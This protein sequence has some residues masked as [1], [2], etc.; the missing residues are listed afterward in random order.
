M[1]EESR[2]A[3]GTSCGPA[4]GSRRA[5]GAQVLSPALGKRSSAWLC[6]Q[7]LPSG[8]KTLQQVR[9]EV[10]V[11]E[12]VPAAPTQ[13]LGQMLMWISLGYKALL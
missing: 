12:A 9:T 7:A 6:S 1:T 2:A 10:P 11:K 3:C 4:L 5:G 13:A 8:D